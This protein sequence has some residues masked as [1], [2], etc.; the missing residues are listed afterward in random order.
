MLLYIMCV[1][2]Y[3]FFSAPIQCSVFSHLVVFEDKFPNLSIFQLTLTQQNV[4][5]INWLFFE[6]LAHQSPTLKRK[7]H[8]L[9]SHIPDILSLLGT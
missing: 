8:C 3:I 4:L 1:Y 2:I 9:L 5:P 7:L 6:A